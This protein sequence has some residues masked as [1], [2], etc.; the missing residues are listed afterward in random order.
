MYDSLH[1]LGGLHSKK[2]TERRDDMMGGEWVKGFDMMHNVVG[3]C[4]VR[5]SQDEIL[6]VT[7]NG[8][9]ER[10][11]YKYNFATGQFKEFD[12]VAPTRV[13]G[14]LFCRHFTLLKPSL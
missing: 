13:K 3:A 7:G 9:T 2:T 1:L 12:M 14:L 6:T 11:V 10:F 8:A 4:V 5:I